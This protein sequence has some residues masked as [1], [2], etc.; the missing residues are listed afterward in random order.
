MGKEKAYL[1]FMVSTPDLIWF[2]TFIPS[3]TEYTLW[4]KMAW[5]GGVLKVFGSF[6]HLFVPI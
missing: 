1:S 3:A 4:M 6:P 2:N 5:G